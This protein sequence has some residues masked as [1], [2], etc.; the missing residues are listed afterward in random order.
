[1]TGYGF[2]G[3]PAKRLYR[4]RF[5]QADVWPAYDGRPSDTVDIDIYEHWLRPAGEQRA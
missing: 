4:V 5:R 1:M 3:L 2:D